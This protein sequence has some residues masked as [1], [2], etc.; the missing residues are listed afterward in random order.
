MR[1]AVPTCEAYRDCWAPFQTLFDKF[2]PAC[3]YPVI[4]YS[5]TPDE[6]WCATVKRIAKESSTPVLLMQDDFF[7]NSPVNA[8][9]IRHGWGELE[10]RKAGC[11]R[12]YPCPGGIEEYGDPLFAIVPRGTTARISCQAAIWSPGFLDDVAQGASWTTGEAG[13]FENLGSPFADG[14]EPEVL[15]FK[16]EINPWPMSYISSAISRG[17][18]N[19]DALALCERLNIPVD[20]SLRPVAA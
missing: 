16:R 15:A 3:P 18:W 20:R 8:G 11:V 5:A 13:D 7:L 9:L 2:W 4:F 12:L 19:P 14:L 17:E 10:N 6:P 1:I